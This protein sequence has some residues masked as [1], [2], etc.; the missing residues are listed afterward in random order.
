MKRKDNYLEHLLN[1]HIRII[2]LILFLSIKDIL[3]GLVLSVGQHFSCVTILTV[4][5]WGSPGQ[6]MDGG[7]LLFGNKTWICP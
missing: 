7:V 3:P 6:R 1:L 4:Q 2:T 5:L